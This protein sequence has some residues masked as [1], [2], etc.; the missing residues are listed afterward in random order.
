MWFEEE[1]RGSWWA[2]NTRLELHRNESDLEAMQVQD[3][4]IE[5]KLKELID[6]TY[7]KKMYL[8]FGILSLK[9][10]TVKRV[11]L[12]AITGRVTFCKVSW[13]VCE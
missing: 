9:N 5:V 11:W 1:P 7:T 13:K 8:L 2:C 6:I 12:G 10:S 4:T 3:C